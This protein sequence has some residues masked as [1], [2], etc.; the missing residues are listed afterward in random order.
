[1]HQNGGMYSGSYLVESPKSKIICDGLSV[2]SCRLSEPHASS[3]LLYLQFNAAALTSPGLRQQVNGLERLLS[4]TYRAPVSLFQFL[5]WMCLDAGVVVNLL[6][7][8]PAALVTVLCEI[9]LEIVAAPPRG[10]ERLRI[11]MADYYGLHGLPPM[12]L[13]QIS[14]RLSFHYTRAHHARKRALRLY[15]DAFANVT[16]WQVAAQRVTELL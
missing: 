7:T 2:A 15:V 9:T 5:N 11:V 12:T 16:W 8:N 10:N 14:E 4:D 3:P 6:S 1:M 13:Q